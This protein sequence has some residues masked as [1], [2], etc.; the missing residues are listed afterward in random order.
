MGKFTGLKTIIE[1]E[2]RQRSEEPVPAKR[3][4]R[5]GKRADPNYTQI[6]L[7]MKKTPYQEAQRRLIGSNQDF[8]DLVNRLIEQWLTSNGETD[9][10]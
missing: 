3:E 4:R 9:R 5:V 7:Y 2:P 6:S 1:G 8:S 10:K